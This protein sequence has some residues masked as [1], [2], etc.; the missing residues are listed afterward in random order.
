MDIEKWVRT[1]RG[2]DLDVIERACE[3]SLTDPRGRG[4]R[5]D[6]FADGGT[7]VYLSADVP[8]GQIHERTGLSR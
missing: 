5:V 7:E 8:F 4:V 1:A 3:E 6:R 2:I